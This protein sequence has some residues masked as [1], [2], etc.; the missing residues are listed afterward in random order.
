MTNNLL[1]GMLT[2]GQ[3]EFFVVENKVKV[4]HSGKI[5][6]FEDT[7]FEIFQILKETINNDPLVLEKLIEMHP[8][9]EYRRIEQFVQCRFG[10]LDYTGDFCTKENKLQDGEYWPC[11]KHGNCSAEGV[12]CRLPTINGE[13]LTVQE[14][15]LIQLTTTDMTN[16]VIAEEMNLPLGTFHKLKHSLYQK[17]GNIQTK[18]CL[19]KIAIAFNLIN[20]H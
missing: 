5:E 6:S 19:T 9:S 17:I 1:P 11:S 16:E 10:G 13:R 2:D 18:Q 4:M 14:I 3:L 8:S 15:Q 20:S 7:P 12:L